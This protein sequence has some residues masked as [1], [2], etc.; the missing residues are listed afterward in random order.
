MN[1]SRAKNILILTFLA[2]NIFLGYRLWMETYILFPSRVVTHQ[3]IEEARKQLN[4]VNLD[5]EGTVPRQFFSMSFLTVTNRL[6]S[7]EVLASS[8]FPE[9]PPCRLENIDEGSEKYIHEK[10][11][12]TVSH[13]GII[14]FTQKLA[15]AEEAAQKL[16]ETE[17][18]SL[19]EDF[20]Q[21]HGLFPSDARLE[22]IYELHNNG[23]FIRYN[24]VY[25][26]QLLFGGYLYVWVSPQGVKRFELYWLQPQGFNGRDII[27]ITAP[28]AL[29]RLTE[30]I[31]PPGERKT[32]KE[33]NVGYFSESFD[34]QKWDMVPVWRIKIS[35]FG[36]FF[37]N[38]YTGELEGK[39]EIISNENCYF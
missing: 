27:I 2:L 33:I 32:V 39:E 9:Q 28:D 4:V 20:L 3:E 17:A 7:G 23:Y 26:N 10:G 1:W 14:K 11:E 19:A 22:D 24:Q 21:E 29:L 34:A 30:V 36:I 16:G 13:T 6:W 5:L 8:L 12:L 25:K 37:I 31:S 38:A 18:I 15:P 35:D